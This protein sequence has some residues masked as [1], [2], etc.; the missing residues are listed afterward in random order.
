M[1]QQHKYRLEQP[2][3]GSNTTGYFIELNDM[4]TGQHLQEESSLSNT[5]LSTI[6]ENK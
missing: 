5:N 4:Y 1:D 6:D 2:R 3:A